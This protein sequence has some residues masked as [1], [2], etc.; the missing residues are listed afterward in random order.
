MKPRSIRCMKF[1]LTL[2]NIV[3]ILFGLI[4]MAICVMNMREK[5]SRPDQQST[6]SKG[7]LSFL[8]TLSL[9][10]VVTAI[11]GCIGAVREH[12]KILYVHACFFMFLVSV[13]VVVGVGGAVLSAWVGGS[14]ELRVQFY[15]NATVEDEP[16]GH[17]DF[18]D[19]LQSEHQ[20]CGVDGPQ[21]YA[22]LNRDIPA[23]CCSRA[24]P[25]REGGARRHLH[26]TC[27]SEKTYYARGCEEVLRQKKATKGNIFIV[28]GVVFALLEILCIVVAL[29]M[30]RTI[31]VERRKLQQNLQAHFET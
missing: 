9:C 31:R 23:S 18:W 6:L 2:F 8:L 19:S 4:L 16:S 10:L 26:A 14:S 11:L 1:F 12:V 30:A 22:I 3:V 27:L 5:K 15:K 21:D 28:T 24:H 13:E 17:Y 29:W 20:C 25:L 7:V